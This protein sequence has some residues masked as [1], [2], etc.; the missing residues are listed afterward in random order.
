[1]FNVA[2]KL[3]LVDLK[4]NFDCYWRI[5]MSDNK[6]TANNSTSELVENRSFI[7][8][9]IIEEIEIFFV[10]FHNIAA[11]QNFKIPSSCNMLTGFS[12]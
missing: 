12:P 5:E 2:L 8:P 1:M 7:K 11:F 6:L 4:Y 9:N 10:T 3:R